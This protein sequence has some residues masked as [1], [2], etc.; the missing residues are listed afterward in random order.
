MFLGFVAAKS[1]L[2]G[3]LYVLSH[4]CIHINVQNSTFYWADFE[5]SILKHGYI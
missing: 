2:L 4:V 5:P 3:I 1:P